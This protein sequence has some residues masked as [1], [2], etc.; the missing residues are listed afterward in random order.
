MQPDESDG[1]ALGKVEK[2][3]FWFLN[4]HKFFVSILIFKFHPLSK[5]KFPK[6]DFSG[7]QTN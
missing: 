4:W 6:K 3:I 5:W 1:P 2:K 7:I